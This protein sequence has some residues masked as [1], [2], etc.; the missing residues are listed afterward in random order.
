MGLVEIVTETPRE[1]EELQESAQPSHGLDSKIVLDLFKNFTTV[2]DLFKA[3]FSG[4]YQIEKMLSQVNYLTK[5]ADWK[6]LYQVCHVNMLKPYYDGERESDNQVL[7][8]ATQTQVQ[9]EVEVMLQEDI[10]EPS[11][12]EWSLLVMLAPKPDGTQRFCMD[13]QK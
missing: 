12:S 13:Y 2:G 6:R 10:T 7:V 9:N 8:T 5:M 11:Q 3:R 4:P 1:V